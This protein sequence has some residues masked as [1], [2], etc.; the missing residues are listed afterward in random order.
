MDG[1][2]GPVSFP[3]SAR[4]GGV[5][6]AG[7]LLTLV[8]VLGVLAFVALPGQQPT[9]GDDLQANHRAE[10]I[11]VPT[12]A[13]SHLMVLVESEEQAKVLQS[14]REV[15]AVLDA[16]SFAAVEVVAPV[17]SDALQEALLF[18]NVACALEGCAPVSIL[19]LRGPGP[20]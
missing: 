19:D 5:V 17:G 9:G 4:F 12:G 7:L 20:E 14:W 15:H 6:Q 18:A 2:A 3:A 10:A 13:S 8:A 1:Q 16:N 11:V